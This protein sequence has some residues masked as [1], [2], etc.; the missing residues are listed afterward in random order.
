L[1][2]F[3]EKSTS[4]LRELTELYIVTKEL[5]L[6]AEEIPDRKADI[7]AIKELRDAFDH[8]MRANATIFGLKDSATDPQDFDQNEYIFRNTDKA[9]GHVYRAGYDT[10]DW[11][12]LKLR[13][14]TQ[15]ATR[16]RLKAPPDSDSFRHPQWRG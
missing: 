9:Y 2:P 8:L 5:L 10:L 3:D 4:K 7:Q 11:I 6:R 13:I 12:C 15:S 16:I 1:I 14:P